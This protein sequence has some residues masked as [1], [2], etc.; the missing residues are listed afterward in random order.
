MRKTVWAVGLSLVLVGCRPPQGEIDA[1]QAQVAKLTQAQADMVAAQEE[2]DAEQRE[3]AREI[4]QREIELKRTRGV[5]EDLALRVAILEDKSPGLAKRPTEKRRPG[6]FDPAAHYRILIGDAHVRGPADAMVTVVTFSDFQCPFCGRAKPTIEALQKHYGDD[7]RFVFMHNPLAFHKDARIAAIAAE[8]AGRQGKF[9]RMHDL[10][11]ENQKDLSEKALLRL[12]KKARLNRG[13]FKRDLKSKA[14]AA[15]VD[16]HQAS[17]SAVGVRG[18]PAF[19]V[20]GRPLSGAQPLDSFK[21]LVDE[22][23]ANARLM[24]DDG[25]AKRDVYERLMADALTGVQ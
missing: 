15:K 4:E 20:N 24:V 3:L 21:K 7:V 16:A 25:I 6:T 8:A 18:T 23:L 12:A 17:A 9:W 5:A 14:I 22:E 2:S 19:F 1:L 11:F 13:R 10:I